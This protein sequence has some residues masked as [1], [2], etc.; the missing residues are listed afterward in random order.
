MNLWHAR[1]K[2][3]EWLATELVEQNILVDEGFEMLDKCIALL[4]QQ[5]R[6]LNDELNGRFARVINLTLAKVRNLLLG[7]YS[8][9]LDA[10]AQEAGA[11]LRPILEAYELLIYFRLEPSRVD[12]AIDGKLP[13]PGKRAKKD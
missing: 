9:L 10:V 8:M 5:S 7:S 13:S 12:Q 3:L 1:Q 11:L 2:S 6:T 4:N